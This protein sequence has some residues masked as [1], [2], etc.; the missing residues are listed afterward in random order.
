LAYPEIFDISS[1]P[2]IFYNDEKDLMNKL[3]EAIIRTERLKNF[4]DIAREHD[5]NSVAKKYDNEFNLL[6]KSA[7]ANKD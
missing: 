2:E 6:I 7:K 5:F 3:K 4:S 1:N